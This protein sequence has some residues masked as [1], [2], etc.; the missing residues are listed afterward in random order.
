MFLACDLESVERQVQLF[1]HYLI[2]FFLGACLSRTEEYNIIITPL[3]LKPSTIFK[4]DRGDLPCNGLAKV[5]T[6]S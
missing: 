2:E 5:R 4:P 6:L 1:V 3:L